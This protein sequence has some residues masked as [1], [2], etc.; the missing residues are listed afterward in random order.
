MK[1]LCQ[2]VLSLGWVFNLGHKG[3]WSRSIDHLTTTFVY[4]VVSFIV[5]SLIFLLFLV[6]TVL[7]IIPW[8]STKNRYTWMVQGMV[9]CDIPIERE[10]LQV[11]CTCHGCLVMSVATRWAG[12][13]K[14]SPR[15]EKT[16]CVLEYAWTQPILTVQRRF[17]CK[18]GKDM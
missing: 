2:S 11:F 3:L 1:N 8:H 14:M 6:H 5:I 15:A 16:F 7:F 18:F 17:R 4:V 10:T 12:W 9:T 13:V